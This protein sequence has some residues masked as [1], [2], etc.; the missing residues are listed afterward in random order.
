MR[1]FTSSRL[2]VFLICFCSSA[3]SSSDSMLAV[4]VEWRKEALTAVAGSAA[5]SLNPSKNRNLIS[6][7]ADA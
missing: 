1:S 3:R 6:G 5:P 7:P 4:M 2:K